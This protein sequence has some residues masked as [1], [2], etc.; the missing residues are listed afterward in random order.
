MPSLHQ[1]RSAPIPAPAGPSFPSTGQTRALFLSWLALPLKPEIRAAIDAPIAR[2]RLQQ[3]AS[4]WTTYNSPASNDRQGIAWGEVSKAPPSTSSPPRTRP[5]PR[6][7]AAVPTQHPALQNHRVGNVEAE[8]LSHEPP[9]HRRSIPHREPLH[10]RALKHLQ[11]DTNGDKA[12]GS[13]INYTVILTPRVS[14]AAR[15]S[16]PGLNSLASV[17]ARVPPDGYGQ[18]LHIVVAAPCR[19]HAERVDVAYGVPRPLASPETRASELALTRRTRDGEGNTYARRFNAEGELRQIFNRQMGCV[20]LKFTIRAFLEIVA[21]VADE[22][23][24]RL[25]LNVPPMLENQPGNS[26]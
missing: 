7:P 6:L 15:R 8:K 22:Y 12:T 16:M 21:H 14:A 5:N 25:V 19:V 10:S 1:T 11:A 20:P 23:W 4:H 2:I 13:S 18:M 3:R 9:S 17:D 26:N 24:W